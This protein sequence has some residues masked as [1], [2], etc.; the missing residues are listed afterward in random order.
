MWP[1]ETERRPQEEI[2]VPVEKEDDSKRPVREEYPDGRYDKKV[3]WGHFLRDQRGPLSHC[4]V[5]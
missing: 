5:K 2:L 3:P 4:Q 1:L